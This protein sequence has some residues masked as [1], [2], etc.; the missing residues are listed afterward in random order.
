MAKPDLSE[1][2]KLSKPKKPPC[3]VGL[4]LAGDLTPKLKDEELQ[5]L[6]AA[7][8]TD[9]SIITAGAVQG[10]L[11]ARGHEVNTNRISNHRR[12]ICSCHG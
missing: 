10:W 4:I 8:D 12:K 5:A 2:Y 7:L 3:Q 1:F 6:N 9:K 11:E